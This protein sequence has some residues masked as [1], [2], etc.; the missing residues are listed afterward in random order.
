MGQEMKDPA[1]QPVE[2]LFQPA[3]TNME[4]YDP[5]NIGGP[6]GTSTH[7]E[8]NE[9]GILESGLSRVISRHQSA[10]LGSDHDSQRQGVYRTNSAGDND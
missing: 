3:F 5:M 2:P 6:G 9:K 7:T 8:H 10:E 1:K 4:D